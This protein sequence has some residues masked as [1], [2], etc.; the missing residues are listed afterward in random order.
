MNLRIIDY[1]VKLKGPRN[2]YTTYL[3]HFSRSQRQRWYSLQRM[4]W[5]EQ[6]TS[7][8]MK[9]LERFCISRNTT[10]WAENSKRLTRLLGTALSWQERGH[11]ITQ[12][13]CKASFSCSRE[14]SPVGRAKNLQS[15]ARGREWSWNHRTLDTQGSLSSQNFSLHG[16]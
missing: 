12:L 11:K 9:S 1:S 14:N 13:R 2:F 4:E 7:T 8:G 3:R 10:G 16:L 15:K 5:I 6:P